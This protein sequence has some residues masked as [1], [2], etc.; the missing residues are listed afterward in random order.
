MDTVAIVTEVATL[1]VLPPC[2]WLLQSF[3]AILLLRQSSQRAGK[4]Q[5]PGPTWQR[6]QTAVPVPG[7]EAVSVIQPGLRCSN[8]GQALPSLPTVQFQFSQL[9]RPTADPDM[10][11]P[12]E[13]KASL[14]AEQPK[15]SLPTKGSA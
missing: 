10:S 11:C 15:S 6:C 14:L 13:D 1:P 5:A 3:C 4:S 12:G 9:A 2:V 8:E 7:T